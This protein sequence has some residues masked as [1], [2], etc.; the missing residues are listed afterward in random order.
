LKFLELS[1]QTALKK[2]TILI[3]CRA[4]FP[5]KRELSKKKMKRKLERYLY[6]AINLSIIILITTSSVVSASD[7]SPPKI[8]Y[9][10]AGIGDGCL[11]T[12]SPPHA[13]PDV[14]QTEEE[15]YAHTRLSENIYRFTIEYSL[16]PNMAVFTGQDGILLVDTG[17][18]EVSRN[19]KSF[20]DRLGKGEVKFIIN[21]HHHGDHAGGNSTFGE[22][23]SVIGLQ[24]I[25]QY[26]SS[27]TL[28]K[29]KE[30]MLGRSGIAY[31]KYYLLSFNGETIKLIPSPGVHSSSDLIIYFSDSGIV[32]MGDLLLT[33]SFPAV[34]PNVK[35]YLKILEKVMDIFPPETK[36]IG[37]HGRDYSME[38]VKNYD[39]MLRTTIEIVNKQIKEGKSLEEILEAK[40]LK[41]WD[42]W[43]EYLTFLN[44][45]R[46]AQAIY[47]SYRD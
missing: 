18:K 31:K 20:A 37:G 26:L 4:S 33:Q 13:S 38:D 45:D 11:T 29:N 12:P 24:N 19:L 35:E 25:D 47:E 32:H 16:R 27:G 1:A 15:K 44:P 9:K 14:F 40:V 6:I 30:P 5:T 22:N 46:W 17:H 28:T 3:R 7:P 10:D 39:K 23:V 34:G 2:M 43:G 8:F 42:S 21:T 36:F 41:E